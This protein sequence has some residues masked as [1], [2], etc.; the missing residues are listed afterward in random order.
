MAVLGM[1]KLPR[2]SVFQTEKSGEKLPEARL[3]A[4]RN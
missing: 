3:L 2:S 1:G 4:T